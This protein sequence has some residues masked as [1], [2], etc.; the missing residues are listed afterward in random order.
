MKE[1]SISDF[2]PS[3]RALLRIM[4]ILL[5]KPT[6]GKTA[7]SQEAGINY[8]RFLKHLEWLESKQLAELSFDNHKVVVRLTNNGR[9]IALLF[10]GNQE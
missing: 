2:E 10:L 6:I 8:T 5:D 9:E 4:Q 3:M 1:R 7:L